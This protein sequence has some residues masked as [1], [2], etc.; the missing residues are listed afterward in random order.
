MQTGLHHKIFATNIFVFDDFLDEELANHIKRY[1]ESPFKKLDKTKSFNRHKRSYNDNW[2]TEPDLHI[3]TLFKPFVD[4]II[5]TN[6]ELIKILNYTVE[7]IKISDMWAN[8][9][10]PGESH[11][12]H[13]HANN[14]LSGVYYLQ[15]DES[16]SIMFND[17]RPAS[18][19]ILPRI[20]ETSK[21]NTNLLG[22]VSTQNRVIIFPS[23]LQHWVPVNKSTNNRI[24][25]SWN[26]QVKGRVGEHHE[27]QSAEF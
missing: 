9:L 13:S 5:E 2:Q 20:K 15:S 26:I 27:F 22:Y 11:P 8:I 6:K 3:H 23:W 14:F 17:P 10:R 25:I 7:D 24:S 12:V 19:V 1:I 21:E 4:K 16:A 18:A